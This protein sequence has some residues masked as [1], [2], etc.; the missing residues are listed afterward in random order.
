MRFTEALHFSAQQEML[1]LVGHLEES[2]LQD[3]LSWLV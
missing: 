2:N 1:T 3:V